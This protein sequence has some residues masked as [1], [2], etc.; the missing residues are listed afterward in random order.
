VSFLPWNPQPVDQLRARFPRALERVYSVP[1]CKR[2]PSE[3]PS[4]RPEH[5]F[6]FVDRGVCY[7]VIASI[8]DMPGEGRWLH[9]SVSCSAGIPSIGTAQWAV[10]Q[11]HGHGVLLFEGY[12]VEREVTNL[13]FRPPVAAG[14]RS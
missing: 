5:V 14:V 11:V 1:F 9:V 10:A 3:G 4:G 13:F 2:F 7:R 8:D 6:D 12:Y